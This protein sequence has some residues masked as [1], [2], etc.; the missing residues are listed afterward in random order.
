MYE[1]NVIH[2]KEGKKSMFFKFFF[3]AFPKS[4]GMSNY[5]KFYV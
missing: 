5:S 3:F 2:G 4:F 1:E